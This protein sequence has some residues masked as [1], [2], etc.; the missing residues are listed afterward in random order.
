MTVTQCWLAGGGDAGGDRR[1]HDVDVDGLDD[2][3]VHAGAEGVLRIF[4]E[5]V[6]RHGEDGH[7]GGVGPVEPAGE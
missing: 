6:G 1:E 7:A 5:G 4:R 2:V 3:R